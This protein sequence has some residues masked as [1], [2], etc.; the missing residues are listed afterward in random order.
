MTKI[1]VF[2]L[3]TSRITV[4]FTSAALPSKAVEAVSF[5]GGPASISHQA[6]FPQ[7]LN[8]CRQNTCLQSK[9]SFKDGMRQ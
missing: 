5:G 3:L 6:F 4:M 7:G 8:V 1:L 9:S 2:E